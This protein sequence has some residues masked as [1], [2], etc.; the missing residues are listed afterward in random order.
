MINKTAPAGVRTS[1][2]PGPDPPS[3]VTKRQAV[4]NRTDQHEQQP[5]PTHNPKTC[6]LCASLR[7]PAQA[8]DG[9]AL[10]KHLAANPLPRQA[11]AA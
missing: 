5:S 7:H 11:V 2:W 8:K 1:I 9:R 10:T 6:N 4:T 3:T